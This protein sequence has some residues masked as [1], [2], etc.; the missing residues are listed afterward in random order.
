MFQRNVLLVFKNETQAP[1]VR[2]QAKMFYE[3]FKSSYYILT[4]LKR[5]CSDIFIHACHCEY[6]IDQQLRLV[7]TRS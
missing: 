2:E 5:A 1:G 4:Q 6:I 7:S 3:L